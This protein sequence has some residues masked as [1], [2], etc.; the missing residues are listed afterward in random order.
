MQ[1]NVAK[2]EGWRHLT[3]IC[4]WFRSSG[5]SY[6]A[7]PNVCLSREIFIRSP[8]QSQVGLG[9]RQRN[10]FWS[11]ILNCCGE[12]TS[13]LFT[14]EVQCYN[15]K[16]ASGVKPRMLVGHR[17]SDIP[18][19]LSTADHRLDLQVV[20]PMSASTHMSIFSYRKSISSPISYQLWCV[21]ASL[22]FLLW[23]EHLWR[24]KKNGI[25]FQWRGCH[26]KPC[27]LHFDHDI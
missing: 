25:S 23:F 17:G 12:D 22:P 16:E 24:G 19:S 27:G 21:L 13:G 15:I 6:L 5:C 20:F 14:V 11:V 18:V 3:H 2:I 10:I 1:K 9:P 8:A 7:V 26:F 4:P